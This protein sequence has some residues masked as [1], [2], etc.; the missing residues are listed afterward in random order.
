MVLA[1]VTEELCLSMLETHGRPGAPVPHDACAG[2]SDTHVKRDPCREGT[3]GPELRYRRAPAG[4]SQMENA[5]PLERP[6]MGA[7]GLRSPHR[8][9]SAQ[10]DPRVLGLGPRACPGRGRDES[11]PHGEQGP[12]APA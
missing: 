6:E 8:G 9:A 11:G 10:R 2:P 1:L 7:V 3:S 4:T 5:E 12:R